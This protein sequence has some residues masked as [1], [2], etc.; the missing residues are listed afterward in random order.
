MFA[1][2]VPIRRGALPF[3]HPAFEAL[4]FLPLALLPFWPA[5]VLWT[6]LNLVLLAAIMAVLR[7]LPGIGKAHAGLLG[8]ALLAYFP[9]VNGLL[10]GQDA[11]LFSFL[12]V[13]ALICLDRGADAAAGVWLGACLFRPQIAIPLVLLLAARR[14]RVLLGFA[15]AALALLGVSIMMMG[16]GWPLQYVRFVVFVEQAGSIEPNIVPNIRGLV[17]TLIGPIFKPAVGTLNVLLSLAVLVPALH[18]IRYGQDSASFVFCLASVTAMLVS[19]HAHSYDL[20]FLVPLVVFLLVAT[21]RG[22]IQKHG[23]DGL[24]LFVMLF[25]TPVYILLVFNVKLFCLFSLVLL[26]LFFRLLRLPAPAAAPA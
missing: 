17:G 22:E 2:D 5:Y 15:G 23:R 20:T 9:L 25:L 10:Q 11:I 19:F 14:W 24:L 16:P 6:V 21:L 1:P 26:G 13:M 4:L 3:N 8:L 18:R 7:R 12:A